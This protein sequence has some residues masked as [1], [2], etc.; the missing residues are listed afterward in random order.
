MFNGCNGKE[1]TIMALS[2]A[3]WDMDINTCHYSIIPIFQY[4]ISMEFY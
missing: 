4:S 1:I 2:F 3:E